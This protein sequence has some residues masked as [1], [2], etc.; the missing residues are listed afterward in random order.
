MKLEK[1][2]SLLFKRW[3]VKHAYFKATVSKIERKKQQFQIDIIS[4]TISWQYEA[5]TCMA[6]PTV[7]FIWQI[8]ITQMSQLFYTLEIVLDMFR[9]G[10]VELFLL[11]LLLPLLF[12]LSNRLK[13]TFFIMAFFRLCSFNG[14]IFA[15]KRNY[16]FRFALCA[17]LWNVIRRINTLT[18]PM[19]ERTPEMWWHVS[20]TAAFL[21]SDD[22]FMWR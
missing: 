14:G 9:F 21:I 13:Y 6:M 17:I 4:P 5:R 3:T 12:F 19:S 22:G 18:Y 10:F 1:C 8:T 16:Y 15:R 20:L 7:I 2:F 11:L